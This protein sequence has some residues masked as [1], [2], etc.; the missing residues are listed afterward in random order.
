MTKPIIDNLT[1]PIGCCTLERTESGA[2]VILNNGKAFSITFPESLILQKLVENEGVVI[3]KHDLIVS[4]WGRPE[5]IGA[6]SLPVAITNL[7]KILE[8]SS[9]KITNI[10]RKGYKIDMPEPHVEIETEQERTETD[11]ITSQVVIHP[12]DHGVLKGVS[13]KL[14]LY[15]S[16]ILLAFTGYIVVYTAFSW[17]KIDCYDMGQASVCSI[18]GESPSNSLIEGKKGQFYFSKQ[19]GLVEVSKNVG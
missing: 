2:Q 1:L 18:K 7:R 14:K 15:V 19:S 6:N 8:L 5:I 12:P 16:F 13:D 17:V 9:I 4:A 10:P 3:T 11:L